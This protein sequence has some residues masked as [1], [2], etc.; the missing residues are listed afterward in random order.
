MTA[1]YTLDAEFERLSLTGT[2][3][4][5][6]TGNALANRIVG[7][8][9]ANIVDGGEGND[10]LHGGAGNDSLIGGADADLLD[11]RLGADTLESGQ[12]ADRFWFRSAIEADGDVIA[13]F[14]AAQGDRIDLRPIDAN[15]QNAG[16][17]AFTWIDAAAFSGVSG[18]LR[19]ENG[20]L[21]GDVD[22]DG[23]ANFRIALT[24]VTSLT[25]AN[26]WV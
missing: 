13:D 8:A 24:D 21:E 20:V 6:G 23:T 11:G 4:L 18:Q 3:D 14:S 16:V 7:N 19:F 10:A 9:G 25:A 15:A 17:H 22:G 2:A 1:N 26:I 12:G 5:N